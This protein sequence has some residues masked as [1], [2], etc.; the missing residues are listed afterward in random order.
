MSI[1][2]LAATTALAW[3]DNGCSTEQFRADPTGLANK[4]LLTDYVAATGAQCLDGTPGAFYFQPGNGNGSNKWY[5]HHQGGGW[6]ESLDDCLGRSKTGLGSSNGYPD[7]ASLG[8]GYFSNDPAQNPLMYNWNKVFMR[9]CDGGSF[10]GNNDTVQEY[11]GAKLFWRGSRIREAVVD[12]LMKTKGLNVATDAVISGCSAGGLAT[13]LHTDQWCDALPNAKCGGLPDSGFFLDYQDPTEVCSPPSTSVVRGRRSTVPGDYHCGL[14]WT[15][16]IQNAT[17]GINKDCIAA[18]MADGT[19]WMC[20]FAE[21]SSEHIKSPVFA[22]QSQ[23]DAW[24]T[25]HVL[26]NDQPV[27]TMGNN[28]T[29]RIQSMLM[30]NNKESGAF[31]DSCHHHCGSW[32]EI[33]IDG[34]LVSVAIQKWW[35]G[36]GTPGSKKLWNQNKNYPCDACCKP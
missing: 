24:Q 26:K 29:A 14:K 5:I 16:T 9:Y 8:G 23:Y 35:E 1:V 7:T 15:Y 17:A 13:Y 4:T 12:N 28:I 20:M 21:H 11:N 2:L 27:Q 10:S 3:E 31:L 19:D 30:A 36:I 32:N 22:M 33:T 18:H 6:C 34:D 25:G